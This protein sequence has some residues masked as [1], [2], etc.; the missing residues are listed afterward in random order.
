M[1]VGRLIMALGRSSFG[2][3]LPGVG[4]CLLFLLVSLLL[5]GEELHSWLGCCG[6]HCDYRNGLESQSVLRRWSSGDR[7]SR[8]HHVAPSGAGGSR[9]PQ[10]PEAASSLSEVSLRAVYR[11]GVPLCT[12]PMNT[13]H[14]PH[15]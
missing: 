1:L 9:A 14:E 11:D 6:P 12:I 7:V 2:V 4:S 8:G 15:S 13:V 5:H 10:V 3:D